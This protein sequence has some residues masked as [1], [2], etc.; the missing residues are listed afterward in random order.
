MV[1]YG[2]TA[3]IYCKSV[4]CLRF[5]GAQVRPGGKC[6]DVWLVGEARRRD[7]EDGVLLSMQTATMR[8]AGVADGLIDTPEDNQANG[9]RTLSSESARLV[10][11]R[12]RE[13]EKQSTPR[14]RPTTTDY[15]SGK[16]SGPISGGSESRPAI[17]FCS[18]L[19][20]EQSI[21]D[22]QAG[23]GWAGGPGVPAPDPVSPTA[24]AVRPGAA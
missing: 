3:V 9:K 7:G 11:R 24:S 13:R 6:E 12:G 15:M 4:E 16:E 21:N 8:P 19:Q 5:P 18:Q 20:C 2:A 10:R 14:K 22:G 17:L 23:P 1:F